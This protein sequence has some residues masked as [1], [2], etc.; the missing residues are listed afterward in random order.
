MMQAQI[1]T[2]AAYKD[3]AEWRDKGLAQEKPAF[4]GG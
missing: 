3:H 2:F 4:I 1:I